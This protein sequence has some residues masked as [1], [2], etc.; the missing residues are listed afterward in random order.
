[1]KVGTTPETLGVTHVS[2]R[3]GQT[4]DWR[5]WFE[6]FGTIPRVPSS[7]KYLKYVTTSELIAVDL[8]NRTET[9]QQFYVSFYQKC[10]V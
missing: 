6:N 1:M 10:A 5:G 3:R 2:V 8:I 7:R 4:A 9:T